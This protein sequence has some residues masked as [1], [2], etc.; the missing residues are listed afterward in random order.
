MRL[1]S[2]LELE[3]CLDSESWTLFVCMNLNWN[4]FPIVLCVACG[5]HHVDWCYSDSQGAS[6][7]F[8]SCGIGGCWRRSK[9]I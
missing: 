9:S 5:G 3:I 4:S 8:C 7:I 6:V 1:A 2:A